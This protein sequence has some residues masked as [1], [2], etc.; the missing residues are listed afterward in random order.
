MTLAEV[1]NQIL[2]HFIKVTV[3]TVPDDLIHVEVP[4][5]LT[6]F[7]E[8]LVKA[9]LIDLEQAGMTRRVSTPTRAAWVL[10]RSLTSFTQQVTL[11]PLCAELAAELINNYRTANGVV[12]HVCD[13]TALNENDIMNLIDICHEL[14]TEEEEKE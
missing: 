3:F 2:S 10:T 11:G 7:K 4:S 1:K 12:N 13:K 14:L 9:A 6:E 5:E 8:E